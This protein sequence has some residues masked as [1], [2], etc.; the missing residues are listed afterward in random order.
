M[1]SVTPKINI[2]AT[3]FLIMWI[4]VPIRFWSR[5][6]T[7]FGLGETGLGL[8]VCGLIKSPLQRSLFSPLQQFVLAWLGTG[9]DVQTSIHIYQLKIRSWSVGI[10]E[11][12]VGGNG[13]TAR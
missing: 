9:H 4:I 11:R 3:V 8:E 12:N 2:V 5:P 7:G 10:G 13:P 6:E 1:F